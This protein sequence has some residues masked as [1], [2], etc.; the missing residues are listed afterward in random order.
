MANEL[1]RL[2]PGNVD[3]VAFLYRKR[4]DAEIR[5]ILASDLTDDE[6]GVALIQRMQELQGIL[7]A[8]CC[9]P[10]LFAS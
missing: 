8:F 9:I 4:N 1:R 6:K 7:F 5:D 2:I 10:I 3:A